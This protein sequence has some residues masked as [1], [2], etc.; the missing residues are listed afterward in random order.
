MYYSFSLISEEEQRAYA[1][2][3]E[4]LQ[5]GQVFDTNPLIYYRVKRPATNLEKLPLIDPSKYFK[6]QED[7]EQIKFQIRNEEITTQ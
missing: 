7:C 4:V 3:E 2:E 5:G 6:Q 1:T